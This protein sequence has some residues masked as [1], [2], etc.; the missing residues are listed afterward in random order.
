MALAL[1]GAAVFAVVGGE[2]SSFDLWRQRQERAR[3]RSA[4]DSLRRVVDSLR[5]YERRVRTDPALQ[6]RLAREEFGMV[7]G[8]RELL[9]RLAPPPPR[10]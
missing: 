1:V 2:Y 5:T 9:Y 4:V 10:P 8:N 7:R 3:L 6:E